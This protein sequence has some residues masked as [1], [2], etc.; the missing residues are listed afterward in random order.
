MDILDLMK[1]EEAHCVSNFDMPS[2]LQKKGKAPVLAVQ[3]E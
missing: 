3:P 2:A 1:T